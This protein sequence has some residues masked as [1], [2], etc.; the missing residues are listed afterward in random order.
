MPQKRFNGYLSQCEL[1][2]IDG[3]QAG[4]HELGDVEVVESE[5]LDIV[6]NSVVVLGK[7]LDCTHGNEVV[8]TRHGGE[9]EASV[10]RPVDGCESVLYVAV[11]SDD[12]IRIPGY[13]VV[14]QRLEISVQP[15]YGVADVLG[16]YDVQNPPVTLVYQR[17]R[18]IVLGLEV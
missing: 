14:V 1:R 11:S 4:L 18:D 6:R 3:A 7:S 16:A 12:E 10:Q 2:D 13:A 9:T 8:E 15:V 5:Y 17:L